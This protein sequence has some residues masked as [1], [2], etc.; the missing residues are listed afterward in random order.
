MLQLLN[1]TL[2]DFDM[3]LFYIPLFFLSVLIIFFIIFSRWNS[4][5]PKREDKDFRI[6]E[7][8]VGKFTYYRP[9]VRRPFFGWGSFFSNIYR[10]QIS[11]GGIWH[12][13]KKDAEKEIEDY[14]DLR[15]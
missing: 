5:F 1:Y 9:E 13:E 8:K 11:A 10:G 14:K 3:E 4:W 12:N 7:K 2:I 15:S 6:R